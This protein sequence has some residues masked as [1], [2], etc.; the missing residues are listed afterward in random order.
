M[1]GTD[2]FQQAIIQYTAAREARVQYYLQQAQAI[3]SR[4]PGATLEYMKELR[5][6]EK[7][8][9]QRRKDAMAVFN[10]AASKNIDDIMAAPQ[11]D[12]DTAF[13]LASDVTTGG[14]SVTVRQPSALEKMVGNQLAGDYDAGRAS[15]SSPQDLEDAQTPSLGQEK[16]LQDFNV[17]WMKNQE[18]RYISTLRSHRGDKQKAAGA[19]QGVYENT[20]TNAKTE[21]ARHPN[22]DVIL[23]QFATQ[24]GL[25]G[26]S[27]D[28]VLNA[29]AEVAA[30]Q[31]TQ[32]FADDLDI[33]DWRNVP[34]RDEGGLITSQTTKQPTIRFKDVDRGK[35]AALQEKARTNREGDRDLDRPVAERLAYIYTGKSFDD[36]QQKE[37]DRFLSNAEAMGGRQQL[38]YLMNDSAVEEARQV[39]AE[40]ESLRAEREEAEAY[41]APSAAKQL[42]D[43]E[44]QT[45]RDYGGLRT[46]AFSGKKQAR[47][48]SEAIDRLGKNLTAEQKQAA[49]DKLVENYIDAYDLKPRHVRKLRRAV[50]DVRFADS[51]SEAGG[52]SSAAQ[53]S[54]EPT[55]PTSWQFKEGAAPERVDDPSAPVT[56]EAAPVRAATSTT[57]AVP[58]SRTEAVTEPPTSPVEVDYDQL[59]GRQSFDPPAGTS[60]MELMARSTRLD[61][62][63]VVVDEFG[64]PVDSET[65]TVEAAPSEEEVPTEPTAAVGRL[66]TLTEELNLILSEPATPASDARRRSIEAQIERLSG[67]ERPNVTG[68]PKNDIAETK[69]F[70]GQLGD[71]VSGLPQYYRDVGALGS[72]AQVEDVASN[73]DRAKRALGAV[74]G[75]G[76]D[77]LGE[78]YREAAG[79]DVRESPDVNEG[80]SE[81]INTGFSEV[82]EVAAL[83]SPDISRMA[84]EQIDA[85]RGTLD[86]PE[87][88]PDISMADYRRIDSARGTLDPRVQPVLPTIAQMTGYGRT[89]AQTPTP[90]QYNEP[91]SQYRVPGPPQDISR[92]AYEQIDAARGTMDPKP[93]DI[94]P[95]DYRR[96][97]AMRGATGQTALDPVDEILG[98]ESMDAPMQPLPPDIRTSTQDPDIR[99][100]LA[101]RPASDAYV[102]DDPD[103]AAVRDQMSGVDLFG[104]SDAKRS[105]APTSSD[106]DFDDAQLLL[107]LEDA[108]S[109]LQSSKGALAHGQDKAVIGGRNAGKL[110]IVAAQ[111]ETDGTDTDMSESL[112]KSAEEVLD[113][114]GITADQKALL[115]KEKE[116]LGEAVRLARAAG[117]DV[118]ATTIVE[119]MPTELR[120][121]RKAVAAAVYLGQI[122]AAGK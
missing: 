87:R 30:S 83:E 71:Y 113:G 53:P 56:D 29:Y 99:K 2:L 36:L 21:L 6:R 75:A 121:D 119:A 43:A 109:Y 102:Y 67:I 15:V 51:P 77:I 110:A 69:R 24:A 80:F 66:T 5:Q 106:K 79:P 59:L 70:L 61:D 120:N 19:L 89:L 91:L 107:D 49:L 14:G 82:D 27:L 16:S 50:A 34:R 10:E 25:D 4:K 112:Q 84:Y 85:A 64:Y 12:I 116:V 46:I 17:N 94:S 52:A 38:A 65:S 28:D 62:D 111:N 33:P 35:I 78:Y 114:M 13:K 55:A 103:K 86:V 3:E 45:F 48:M 44:L 122:E 32:K 104:G 18:Q 20:L 58:L 1:I 108:A 42:L 9:A 92:M 81:D 73:V 7:D 57:G 74:L 76:K 115:L 100:E 8:L 98:Y 72:T 60:D 96:I 105:M 97:A 11:Q 90:V 39:V 54:T 63:G 68:D 93:Q 101:Q 47:L 88:S 117:A 118:S 40:G 95:E 23:G 37:R 41:K 22:R 31:A 26:A